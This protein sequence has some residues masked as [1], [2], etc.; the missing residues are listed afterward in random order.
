MNQDHLNTT[1]QIC[2]AN[3][4]HQSSH[5]NTITRDYGN[6]DLPENLH[7]GKQTEFDPFAPTPENQAKPKPAVKLQPEVPGNDGLV[8]TD[9]P[10][11]F[12]IR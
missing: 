6:F 8:S 2:D 11:E 4:D 3:P 12:S 5:Q 7:L 1:S 10:S 9:Q